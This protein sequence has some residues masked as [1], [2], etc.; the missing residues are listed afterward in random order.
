MIVLQR[1]L[2]FI[3]SNKMIK[4]TLM[5]NNDKAIMIKKIHLFLPATF[6]DDVCS[7]TCKTGSVVDASLIL[8][9][10]FS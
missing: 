6:N 5:W 4:D 2:S 9:C 7:M 8:T 10:R 1:R 3:V